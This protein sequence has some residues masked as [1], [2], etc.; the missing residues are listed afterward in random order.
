MRKTY[1]VL[2]MLIMLFL[3]SVQANDA[4][5]LPPDGTPPS[6]PSGVALSI[7]S[8][9]LDVPYVPTP[10][11]VVMKMLEMTNVCS[12]DTVYDL[13][14]G[15]GRIV[16]TAAEKMGA[17][18]VGID[19]DPERIRESNENA[20]KARVT[21]RVR[22]LN[23]DLF[24]TDFSKASVVTLYLLPSVNLDL[25][26]KLLREL[27]PGSRV[28]SHDFDMG[29]WEADQDAEVEGHSIYY[30]VI[31][32]NATGTWEWTMPSRT[33]DETFVL[34]V[35]QKFQKVGGVLSEGGSDLPIRDVVLSGNTLKFTADRIVNGRMV[36]VRYEGR[37]NGDSIEG[38]AEAADGSVE[39]GAKWS[40]RRSPGTETAI[41]G[42]GETARVSFGR[43]E[44]SPFS[45]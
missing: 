23:Q 33:G 16:I 19:L 40:A 4:Y 25:R 31:P 45:A 30:W 14:C 37:I 21:N 44:I 35:D 1:P 39:K 15:D 8:E 22:F 24:K 6:A 43:R 18:G 20:R 42:S 10:E 34:N 5:S 3:G 27:K 32:A 13:G 12:E 9:D 2:L 17:G 28:V 11:N 36:A 38:T 7:D 26:P 29:E 41:D